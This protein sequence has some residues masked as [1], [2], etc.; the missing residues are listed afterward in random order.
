M[1]KFIKLLFIKLFL[2]LFFIVN[3]VYGYIF[4]FTRKIIGKVIFLVFNTGLIFASENPQIN[5]Q[6]SELGSGVAMVPAEVGSVI[7]IVFIFAIYYHKRR[8]DQTKVHS[9]N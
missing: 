8:I 4:I 7:L 1:I 2:S 6:A 9:F 3:K 5:I